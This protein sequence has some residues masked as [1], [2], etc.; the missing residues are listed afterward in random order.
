LNRKVLETMKKLAFLLIFQLLWCGLAQA[1]FLT[2]IQDEG[3]GFALKGKETFWLLFRS[4]PFQGIIYDLKAP[5]AYV[6]LPDG[7][8][9]PVALRRTKIFDHARGEKR[10]AWV[11]HYLPAQKGDHF[12]IL[13]TEP[14]LVPGLNEV[15]QEYVKVPFHISYGRAWEKTLSL[16]AEIVFLSQPYGLEEGALL[17]GKVLLQGK[18][19]PRALVQVVPYHGH[20]LSP[21]DLPRNAFGEIEASRM[22]QSALTAENGAFA[23]TLPRA[24]WWLISAR[25]PFGNYKIGELTYPLFLRASTWIYVFPRFKLP[26]NAPR[27]EAEPYK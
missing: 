18:P 6:I 2:V 23:V 1:F 11:A 9:E 20:Y 13:E 22:Y 16:P 14:T 7:K 8:K 12:L 4:E 27:L 19:M 24:G 15:W 17:R 10:Y 3:K 21:K 26:E 25:L 5:R